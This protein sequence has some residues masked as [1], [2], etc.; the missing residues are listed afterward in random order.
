M[1]TDTALEAS[2]ILRDGILF[3]WYVITLFALVVYI[4]AVEVERKIWWKFSSTALGPSP[5]II[6][7][8]DLTALLIFGTWLRWI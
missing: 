7:G 6:L 1:P 3:Q 8:V 5:G 4:Y 2:K